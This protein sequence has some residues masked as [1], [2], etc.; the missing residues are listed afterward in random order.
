MA[1]QTD[2]DLKGSEV[3]LW[4][5]IHERL[6][7]GANL[8]RIDS[9]IWDLFGDDWAVVFTDLSGFSRRVAEFGIIH[10]LQIIYEHKSVLMPVI[11]EHDGILIKIEADSL[12]IIFKQAASAVRCAMAMQRTCQANNLTRAP[13]D[14]I[15]LCVGVGYGRVLRIGDKDVFG[16]EVNAAS[17]L[18]E[19]IAKPNE[20]LVTAAVRQ[21]AGEV[22]DLRYEDLD[23]KVPGSVSNFRVHYPRDVA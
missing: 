16:Q 23:L 18:G 4:K 2:E 19:D 22:P 3:R 11:G 5:L 12:L 9:R 1:W 7:P 8:Q 21:A 6:Q 15:L 10:F 20:I 17:K 14:Q 13:E